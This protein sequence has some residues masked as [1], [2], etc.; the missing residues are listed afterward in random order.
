MTLRI[1]QLG[2]GD[3]A[4]YAALMQLFAEAFDD[5][6][7]YASAPPDA[8]HRQRVLTRPELMLLTA[9]DADGRPLGGLLAY[10]LLK[11]EQARSEIYLY[12]LAVRESAR[13]QGVATALI[14]RLRE[15][16][17]QRGAWVVYVQ[18]DLGDEPAIALYT[19]LGQREDVL[20][21]D[22]AP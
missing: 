2:P 3:D 5:P 21:F 13:R 4:R 14:E 12:D 10:E 9:E 18:A 15:L 7:S 16:A 8:A 6:E 20:H 19:K 17:R 11:P 1:R 22:I